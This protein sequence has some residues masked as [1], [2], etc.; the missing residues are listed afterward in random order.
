MSRIQEWYVGKTIFITGGTGFMGKV[1]VEKILRS[2]P[3][4]KKVILLIRP[5]RGVDPMQR[6]ENIKNLPVFARLKIERPKALDKLVIIEGNLEVENLGLTAAD[7]RKLIE[8]SVVMHMAATLRLEAEV[9]DAVVANTIGTK[10][11]LD[12]CKNMKTLQCFIHLS[13]AFCYPDKEILDEKVYEPHRDPYEVMKYVQT[14]NEE[15]LKRKKQEILGPHPNSYT[16]SKRLAEWLVKDYA[17]EYP[18]VIARPS[19]VIPTFR[20]PM[21]GWVDSLNGPIGVIAAAGKGVLR[22]MLCVE[23][24]LAQIIPCDLAINA[25]LTIPTEREKTKDDM[26]VYN[27]NVPRNVVAISWGEILN[28]GQKII[29]QYPF[30]WMLW[31]PDGALRTNVYI[32]WLV[33]ILFQW[34]PAIFLDMLFFLIG[35]ERFMIRV[36]KKIMVGLDVLQYFTTRAWQFDTT[37]YEKMSYAVTGKDEEIFY[38][39][40]VTYDLTDYLTQTLLMVKKHIFKERFENLPYIRLHYKFLWLLHN[41]IKFTFLGVMVLFVVRLLGIDVL[42]SRSC[43]H[44]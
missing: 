15:V 28:L 19:V 17:K 2:L 10:M 27:L 40:N 16:F 9:K 44:G 7:K 18:V 14:E 21:Q 43:F 31:Y 8:V 29:S 5:K 4:V 32:H 38:H 30:E 1:L 20:E 26:L 25:L 39:L 3:D 13:T 37:N 33:L 22:S 24:N 34:I 41:T 36:Q 42:L 35:R 12:L 23:S 11:I 6:L